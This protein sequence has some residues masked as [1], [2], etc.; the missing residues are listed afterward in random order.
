MP[1]S[2]PPT[3]GDEVR[4]KSFGERGPIV[5]IEGSGD[6]AV[7]AVNSRR[8]R[9]VDADGQ[10]KNTALEPRECSLGDLEPIS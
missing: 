8:Y 6:S 1:Q 4:V 2:W 3:V 10:I 7:Y 5:R 9:F